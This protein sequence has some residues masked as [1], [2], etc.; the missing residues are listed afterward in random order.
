MS[1][2]LH[3]WHL[4][5]WNGMMNVT[6]SQQAQFINVSITPNGHWRTN[7]FFFFP[8]LSKLCSPWSYQKWV[9]WVTEGKNEVENVRWIVQHSRKSTELAIRRAEIHKE[10]LNGSSC[11]RNPPRVEEKRPKCEAR[12]KRK[13]T[14]EPLSKSP[15]SRCSFLFRQAQQL[16]GVG[17]SLYLYMACCPCGHFR[18]WHFKR[19]LILLAII[20]GKW[21]WK[22]ST[23]CLLFNV[24]SLVLPTIGTIWL[25]EC[26]IY[27]HVN[28]RRIWSD[29]VFVDYPPG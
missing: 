23:I 11:A 8:L 10:E 29:Y 9:T 17:L 15:Y 3:T 13:I 1:S 5:G 27:I 20:R 6:L 18:E 22:I 7:I 19:T 21:V 25:Y 4:C 16:Q 28:L 24:R 26:I 14:K 2:P 12:G